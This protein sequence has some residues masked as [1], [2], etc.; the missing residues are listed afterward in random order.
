MENRPMSI[1]EERRY[2]SKC[3]TAVLCLTYDTAPPQ[4]EKILTLRRSN[5]AEPNVL[6]PYVHRGEHW[7]Y[8]PTSQPMIVTLR[9]TRDS[10]LDMGREGE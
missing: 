2:V 4:A 5:D 6:E 3:G 10:N 7:P 9:Q 8:L 1:E